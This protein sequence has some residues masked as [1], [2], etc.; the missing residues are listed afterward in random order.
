MI[1]VKYVNRYKRYYISQ[2]YGIK[3]KKYLALIRQPV[4]RNIILILCLKD[5][6]SQK[7]I[8]DFLKDVSHLY[9]HPTTVAFHLEKLEKM[10]LIESFDFGNEKKYML[11]D[12]G[13]FI[14]FFIMHEKSF[15]DHKLIKKYLFW[16][17]DL[18]R[19]YLDKLIEEVYRILPHPY[20]A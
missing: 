11:N 5:I 14:D 20:Y 6:F 8:I 13:I 3:E 7:Q 9:K 19:D 15:F 18:P 4:T 10:G 17:D 12:R 2:K 16:M 1:T